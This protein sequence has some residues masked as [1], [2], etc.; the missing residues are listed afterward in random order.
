MRTL[1][2]TEVSVYSNCNKLQKA[3]SK[4]VAMVSM[5]DV[6][7]RAKVSKATVSRVLNGTGEVSQKLRQRVLDC[8]RELNYTINHNIQDLV[9]KGRTG[10]TR[11][12]AMV[13]VG[14]DFSDPAYAALMDGIA[15]GI[16]RF[17]YNLTLV[18]LDGTE[19]DLY[20]LPP[21]LRDGRADGMLVS[22]EL[23]PENLSLFRQLGMEVIV[24]GSYTSS[25]MKDFKCVQIN[26][27]KR[28]FEAAEAALRH[29]CRR[30][31]IFEEN[32]DNYAVGLFR[33]S[34][35]QAAA[36]YGLELTEGNC[37]SGSGPYHG[38]REPLMPLFSSREELPFDCIVCADYRTATEIS[39]MLSA[40]CGLLKVPDTLIVT[41]APYQHFKLSTPA[42]Y[43][44]CCSRELALTGVSQLVERLQNKTSPAPV[45]IQV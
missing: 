32:P 15:E 28:A 22:G 27:Q 40:R 8:C 10:T 18:K 45:L 38:A 26:F 21:M 14:R 13:L 1:D 16:R 34:L 6:A 12:I 29:N 35:F 42:V 17:N 19:H 36:E 25:L 2:M 20:D 4:G 43:L 44:D 23:K 31:A 39:A 3:V 5:D 9:L 11:N 33:R 24:I 41:T 30:L 37:Y 7:A